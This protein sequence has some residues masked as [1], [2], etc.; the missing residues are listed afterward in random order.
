MSRAKFSAHPYFGRASLSEAAAE[1]ALTLAAA[2]FTAA[3]WLSVG[4]F[5][6]PSA[7]AN[8]VA[9]TPAVPAIHVTLPAVE[10]VGRRDSLAVVPVATTAQNTAA[11][12]VNLKQ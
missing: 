7:E 12:P 1:V 6:L 8:E 4:A 11:F 10:I 2:G 9:A 3:I 5:A